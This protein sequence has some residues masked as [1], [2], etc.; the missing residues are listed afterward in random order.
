MVKIMGIINLTP[1]SF[2]EKSRYNYSILDSKA[3]I[4]DV[5]AVSTRPGA[6]D[7]SLEEEW[8]RLEPFLLDW[9]RVLNAEGKNEVQS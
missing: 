1:D 6:E 9:N 3:D 5:G 2:F 4:V 7:V 8:R